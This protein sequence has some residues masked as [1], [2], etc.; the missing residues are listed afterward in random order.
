MATDAISSL[1]DLHAQ[2]LGMPGLLFDF[3]DGRRSA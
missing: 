2:M 3:I 1:P